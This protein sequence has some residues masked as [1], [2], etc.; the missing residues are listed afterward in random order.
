MRKASHPALTTTPK[1]I[2]TKYD[3]LGVTL[4]GRLIKKGMTRGEVLQLLGEPNH[5][6]LGTS[7]AGSAKPTHKW[8][9]LSYDEDGTRWDLYFHESWLHTD[10]RSTLSSIVGSGW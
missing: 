3:I 6:Q 5:F 10:D 7:A 4:R 2:H 9:C 8:F 1:V